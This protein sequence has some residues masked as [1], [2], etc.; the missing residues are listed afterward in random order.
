LDLLKLVVVPVVV[1][2]MGDIDLRGLG[3]KA[4]A[5]AGRW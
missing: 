1:V 4:D 2:E 3:V 5:L